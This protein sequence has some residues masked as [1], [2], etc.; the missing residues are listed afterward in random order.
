[1]TEH[2]FLGA[3]LAVAI[4][5]AVAGNLALGYLVYRVYR[6]SERTEGLIAATYLEA[7]RALEQ[8]R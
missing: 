8:H 6:M 5:V 2:G 1:M 7:K 4:V 3:L